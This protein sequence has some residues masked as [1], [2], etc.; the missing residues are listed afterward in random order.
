[1]SRHLN[2][3]IAELKTRVEGSCSWAGLEN[4]GDSTIGSFVDSLHQEQGKG[5]V[6]MRY[7]FDWSLPLNAPSLLEGYV[8]DGNDGTGQVDK[9]GKLRRG[10]F[11]VPRYF[12]N[13][14]L[15]RTPPGSLY[16]ES[17]PSLFIG[18]SGSS[19]SLHIDTFGSHFWMILVEGQKAWTIFPEEVTALLRPTYSYSHD[20]AFPDAM[21]DP[22]NL[23][24]AASGNLDGPNLLLPHADRYDFVLNP[25]DCLFVPA[26]C[27]HAVRN[28]SDTVALSS[29]FVDG[30]NLKQVC[31]ELAVASLRNPQAAALLQ[32]LSSSEFD[33]TMDFSL[34]DLP[35]N[36]FKRP[37]NK[38]HPSLQ[39]IPA[40]GAT[41]Q[42]A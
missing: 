3:H 36:L 17:W 22:S 2:G 40:S 34:G 20:A 31:D 37:T 18:P 4:A 25:G 41:Q 19:C 32:H 21:I 23:D 29:N 8:E 12:C 5:S 30:S 33:S 9:C 24:S 15:Q 14:L 26:G 7:L 13:D 28:L 35:W 1:L 6:E 16:R 11:V 38:D 42:A 27:A 39:A 10:E